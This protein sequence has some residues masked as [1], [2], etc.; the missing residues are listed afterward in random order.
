MIDFCNPWIFHDVSLLQ[1]NFNELPDKIMS[2]TSACFEKHIHSTPMQTFF[3]DIWAM[4]AWSFVFYNILWSA[5]KKKNEAHIHHGTCIYLVLICT[6][7]KFHQ[8]DLPVP[9]ISTIEKNIYWHFKNAKLITSP[10][11]LWLKCLKTKNVDA[12]WFFGSAHS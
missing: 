4:S 7:L 2:I 11:L 6:N 5:K 9:Q 3:F 10:T 12:R 8:V 1:N